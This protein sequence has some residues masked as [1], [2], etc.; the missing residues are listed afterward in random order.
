MSGSL[1][2]EQAACLA[3]GVAKIADALNGHGTLDPSDRDIQW[4]RNYG[5]AE[6][7]GRFDPDYASAVMA[8]RKA[9]CMCKVTL[10]R[11]DGGGYHDEHEARCP[12]L[13]TRELE[14]QPRSPENPLGRR[15]A[16]ADSTRGR[17]LDRISGGGRR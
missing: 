16:F 10:T 6:A 5:A 11:L 1:S 3:R 9:G 17:L 2:K 8:I 12:L 15:S 13:L 14:R 4:C 7:A